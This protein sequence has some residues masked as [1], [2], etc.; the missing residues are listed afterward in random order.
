MVGEPAVIS[1]AAGLMRPPLGVP[2]HRRRQVMGTEGVLD[3]HADAGVGRQD[4]G[5]TD[6]LRQACV[7]EA[8]QTGAAGGCVSFAV[9]GWACLTA[10][11]WIRA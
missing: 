9:S 2:H 4:Q 7:L 8:A 6:Q 3:D 5:F 11:A 1:A 10:R